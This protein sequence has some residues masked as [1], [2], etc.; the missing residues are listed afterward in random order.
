MVRSIFS[1]WKLLKV[2]SGNNR[3][4][5]VNHNLSFRHWNRVFHD[6]E[7]RIAFRPAFVSCTGTQAGT[8]IVRG[9]LRPLVFP[10]G[11]AIQNVC[12]ILFGQGHRGIASV[13]HSE[14]I[15]GKMTGQGGCLTQLA[16]L[17]D[18]VIVPD[19]VGI[20]LRLSC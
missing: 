15:G 6:T 4:A 11:P 13:G 7:E 12:T 10:A 18:P 2:A 8:L 20:D 1:S 17:A 3:I 19:A 9:V 5:V 14:V 16:R